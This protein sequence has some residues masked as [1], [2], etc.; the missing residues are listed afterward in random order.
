M[1]STLIPNYFQLKNKL[2]R[3]SFLHFSFFYDFFNEM[4][5]NRINKKLIEN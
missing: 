4:K 3:E 1:P 5:F 2:F